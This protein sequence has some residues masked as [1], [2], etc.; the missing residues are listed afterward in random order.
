MAVVSS[1]RKLSCYI[2]EANAQ[3][4]LRVLQRVRQRARPVRAIANDLWDRAHCTD[5][6][7]NGE[8]GAGYGMSVCPE[9][10]RLHARN[11]G[12]DNGMQ[13][14]KEKLNL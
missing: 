13:L 12:G 8:E 4:A 14:R 5:C 7:G 6:S 10:S 9:S 2:R 1:W 11:N 3:N